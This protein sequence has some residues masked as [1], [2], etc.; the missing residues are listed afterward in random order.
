M[1]GSGSFAFIWKYFSLDTKLQ[2]VLYITVKLLQH[3][4]CLDD[5]FCFVHEIAK[6]I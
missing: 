3:L 5:V 4:F 6:S 1:F 2:D